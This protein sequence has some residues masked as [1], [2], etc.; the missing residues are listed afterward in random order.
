ML[1]YIN[2]YSL[3]LKVICRLIINLYDVIAKGRD[4]NRLNRTTPTYNILG[5]LITF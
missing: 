1:E 3:Q 5:K 4:S 2:I